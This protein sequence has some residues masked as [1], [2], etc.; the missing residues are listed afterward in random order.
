MALNAAKLEALEG[1]EIQV[2]GSIANIGPGLDTLAVAVQ[3]YL[4]VTITS[5]SKSRTG[6]LRFSF[7]NRKLTGENYIERAFHFAGR[8][9]TDFPSLEI[10]VESHIPMQSG[11]G[12][13][14]AAT[15]AGLRLYELVHGAVSGSTVSLEQLLTWSTKLEGHP[16]NASAALLGGLAVSYER[17]D[18][19]IRAFSLPWPESLKLIVATPRVGLAT[20]KSRQ[21]LPATVPLIDAVANM[22]SVLLLV[23]AIETGDD[24][25]LADSLQDRLHEPFRQSLVPGLKEIQSI[26]HPSLIGSCLSGAGPSVVAFARRNSEEIKNL[27][28]DVYRKLGVDVEIRIL[29]GHCLPA[30]SRARAI[31]GC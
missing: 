4:H 29:T 21:A 26:R 30:E 15:V 11:L 31:Q 3:L 1:A 17:K 2:A 22:Q 23:R 25:A 10:E 20:A 19:T 14:A 8:E 13:S 24:E 5:V 12:S 9:F 28:N 7:G 18:G 16:D 6:E 27:M